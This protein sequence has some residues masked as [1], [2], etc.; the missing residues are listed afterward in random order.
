MD[1]VPSFYSYSCLATLTTNG[2]ILEKTACYVC[3]NVP[4][5]SRVEPDNIA[6]PI[7]AGLLCFMWC[8]FQLMS[9]VAV[10]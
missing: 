1:M 6:L 2:W 8:V 10:S 7:P 9:E 4:A 5:R 3:L